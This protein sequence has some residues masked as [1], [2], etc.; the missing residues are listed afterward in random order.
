MVSVPSI[1]IFV[2]F[3]D[4]KS[5]RFYMMRSAHM[6]AFQRTEHSKPFLRKLTI[7]LYMHLCMSV[8]MWMVSYSKLIWFHEGYKHHFLPKFV[9][10]R[11]RRF[12]CQ[13]NHLIWFVP[14]RSIGC[15]FFCIM[16]C[17]WPIR[18]LRKDGELISFHSMER[19]AVN[20]VINSIRTQ[21][22]FG[23]NKRAYRN[24][25]ISKI[26]KSRVLPSQKNS[27]MAEYGWQRN[28][29]IAFWLCNMY[30]QTDTNMRWGTLL[31]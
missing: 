16:L 22:F 19:Y 30:N 7:S 15:P 17:I 3:F 2:W 25:I 8:C 13:I 28:S 6:F 12:V 20:F 14:N 10:K 26:V 18:Y 23:G 9:N 27:Y 21:I 5:N 11:K 4:R 1:R 24:T 31:K 29:N